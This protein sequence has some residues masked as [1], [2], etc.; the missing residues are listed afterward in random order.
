MSRYSSAC[1]TQLVGDRDLAAVLALGAFVLVGLHVDEVDDAAD[2]LLGPDRDLG[3]DGV[4]AEGGLEGVERPE[5]V[6]PLAVEHVHEHHAGD[7]ELGGALP[8]A[9]RRDLDA[10]DGVDDEDGR[11]AHA[12]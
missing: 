2:V 10:H 3:G 7:V 12:Q 1:A 9:L 4:R 5:E 11:L 8:E 6:G